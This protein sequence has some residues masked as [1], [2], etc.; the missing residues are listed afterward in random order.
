MKYTDFY[1]VLGV[2]EI[3]S[4]QDIRRAYRQLAKQYHPDTHPGDAQAEAR[5]RQIQEAYEVL[6]DR[7]KRARFDQ[8]SR[9]WNQ[10]QTFDDVVEDL[11]KEP[12]PAETSSAPFERP[13]Q[14]ADALFQKN[15]AGFYDTF[16]GKDTEDFWKK[17][18]QKPTTPEPVRQ[19][20]SRQEPS[21]AE[22]STPDDFAIEYN[23][24][25][26]LEEALKGTRRRIQIHEDVL[27]TIEVN[28]PPGVVTGSR[29]RIHRK[30]GDFYL[31]IQLKPHSR[32]TP[33]GRDLH[34]DLEVM[35]YE[36][37]LGTRKTVSTL[38][39]AIQMRVPRGSQAGKTF[40]IP[41]H[42]LPDVQ[43]DATPGNLF[44]HLKV[45]VSQDLS[46]EEV[47]LME[48]FRDLRESH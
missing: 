31:L 14:D 19:E 16:F 7:E 5:F 46:P 20:P 42:G 13:R 36:A 35:D 10:Y 22:T 17:R 34:C 18:G 21:E 1:T 45:K 2:S 39:G 3:A 28:I 9:N 30:M 11:K 12:T 29:V 24:K 44:V 48:R 26:T 33:D 27:K 41:G 25:I 43:K 37:I 47:T 40:R 4:P 6:S 23:T 15:F 32:F 8:L 38:S